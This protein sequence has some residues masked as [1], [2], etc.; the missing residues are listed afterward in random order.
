MFL[1]LFFDFHFFNV[2][3][4][5]L[6]TLM[7]FQSFFCNVFWKNIVH[8]FNFFCLYLSQPENGLNLFLF[9]NQFQPCCSSYKV[10][11][12]KRKIVIGMTS[13]LKIAKKKLSLWRYLKV[14][15]WHTSLNSILQGKL[16]IMQRMCFYKSNAKIF[17]LFKKWDICTLSG[18]I[19][20]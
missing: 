6:M 5:F 8:H 15:W 20:V 1:T 3:I 13:V 11:S 10:C 16:Y 19:L 9:F 4:L 17:L 2:L 14:T 18:N 7:A 12:Y